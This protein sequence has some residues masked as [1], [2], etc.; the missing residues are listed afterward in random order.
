MASPALQD[1]TDTKALPSTTD[2]RRALVDILYR[3]QFGAFLILGID[4]LNRTPGDNM[5]Q[6]LK[7]LNSMAEFIP[8]S[9]SFRIADD[10]F[11]VLFDADDVRVHKIPSSLPA[12][13]AEQ[14][15][16]RVSCG[17]VKISSEDYG[18][19]P[20][21]SDMIFSTAQCVLTRAQ[22]HAIPD[23]VWLTEKSTEDILSDISLNFFREIARINAARVQRMT[24]ESRTDFLT[25]LYNRRG[26]EA[27]FTRMVRR[28]NRNGNPLALYYIDS[29]SLKAINDSKGHDAGDR[30]IV[31]LAQVLND[32][33][34]ASD[35]L[36]RWAGDEFAAVVEN[37]PRARAYA[38]ARRLNRAVDE[39]TE[40][41]I[42]IGV[43]HGVPESTED[44]FR[45]ADSA[46][47]RVKS[48]GKN[49][50][51]LADPV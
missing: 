33:L 25:G 8:A 19:H 38:I 24:L 30:F 23:V 45:Q 13:I 49:D 32:M 21:M 17:G 39:R 7:V 1:S 37:T 22:Q 20:Q 6:A 12:V 51:E 42:S 4:S 31:D 2:L 27:V 48:R 36:S 3:R 11:A 40:G 29:D 9:N 47:Y 46:L 43:Y 35:L 14:T 16:L 5:E 15:G 10:K 50:I 41:T 28:A 34:R 18:L 26:F 44:A